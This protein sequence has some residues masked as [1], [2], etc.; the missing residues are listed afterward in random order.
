MMTATKPEP[1][2]VWRHEKSRG[3]YTVVGCYAE[4]VFYISCANMG[5]WRRP[6]AEFMDGRFTP[7]DQPPLAPHWTAFREG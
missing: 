6:L 4:T 7:L 5:Q 3:I 1:G 2:S